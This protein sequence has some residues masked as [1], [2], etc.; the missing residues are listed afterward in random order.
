MALL[1]PVQSLVWVAMIG[2]FPLIFVIFFMRAL[3]FAPYGEMG[4]P[5]RFSGAVIACTLRRLPTFSVCLSGLG[6]LARQLPR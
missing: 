1:P 3:Y 2:I 4:L 5:P 6:L